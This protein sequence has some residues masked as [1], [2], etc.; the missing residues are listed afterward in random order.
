M[1]LPKK[2]RAVCLCG[3]GRQVT[4][5]MYRFFSNQCQQNYEYQ[6]YISRWKDGL[7]V[8][9]KGAFVQISGHI[10]RYLREKYG[11]R[12]S[13]C[14]WSKQHPLTGKIPLEV[15]HVNGDASDNREENLRLLC[16]NCH[17]LTPN[18]RAL[19]KGKGRPNRRQ[20]PA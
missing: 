3:C 6:E 17:S 15:D 10:K 20:T 2:P 13:S 14:G 1:S 9:S 4:R 18:F 8:G 11:D 12:C 5:P 16:P 7:E 19:N